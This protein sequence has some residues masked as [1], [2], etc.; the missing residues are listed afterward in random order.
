[1]GSEISIAKAEVSLGIINQ[2]PAI[3]MININPE[4][5]YSD[6][7]LRC[8]VQVIDESADE[9]LVEYRW[10]KNSIMLEE[11]TNELSGFEEQDQITCQATPIDKF[12]L[13][14]NSKTK[15]IQIKET[16]FATKATMFMLNTIGLET[17]TSEIV[18]LQQQGMASVTGYVI[19]EVSASTSYIPL[20][21]FLVIVLLLVNL[22]IFMRYKIKQRMN[23]L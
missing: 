1:M 14:G 6:S 13:R 22:N 11:K 15:T 19:G 2:P 8:E 23:P 5:A 17:T 16:T 18:I 4:Q 20:L 3:A 12:G 7:K 10:Y 21:L 9:V